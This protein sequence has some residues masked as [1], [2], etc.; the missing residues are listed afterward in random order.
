[1]MMKWLND[2]GTIEICPGMGTTP[3]FVWR[4]FGTVYILLVAGRMEM[5]ERDACA[6]EQEISWCQLVS[7]EWK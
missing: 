6:P 3:L 4:D 5:G 1:M 7:R 2:D